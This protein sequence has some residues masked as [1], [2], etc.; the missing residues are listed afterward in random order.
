MREEEVSEGIDERKGVVETGQ[1]VAVQL[2]GHVQLFAT[3]WTVAHQAPLSMG[4][5]RQEYWS[6]FPFPSPGDLPDPGVESTSP[7]SAGGFFTTVPPGKSSIYIQFSSVAQSCPTLCNAMNH[8][9]QAS[10][11]ITNSQSSLKLRSI[12][13]VMPSSH[14]ILC[15]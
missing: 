1:F 7:V 9:S 8:S 2:L 6:G 12:E 3:P 15:R 11:S 14:L 13:S 5:F 4:F 10:L